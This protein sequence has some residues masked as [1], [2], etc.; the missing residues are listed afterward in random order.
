MGPRPTYLIATIPTQAS[1][2][3]AIV[4]AA[5]DVVLLDEWL[6]R[7]AARRSLVVPSRSMIFPPSPTGCYEE[8]CPSMRGV[9]YQ[10]QC[11][12][13]PDSG[14]ADEPRRAT[15]RACGGLEPGGVRG[16]RDERRYAGFLASPEGRG[17]V[18]R[19]P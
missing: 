2:A 18:I 14:S 3:T 1:S 6:L 12:Q 4:T 11:R 8:V 10:M 15:P 16:D 5:I 19:P 17:A 13:I 9:A 7:G